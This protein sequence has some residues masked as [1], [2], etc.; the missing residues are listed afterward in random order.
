MDRRHLNLVRTLK[1][2]AFHWILISFILLLLHN[3]TVYGLQKSQYSSNRNELLE[4]CH[5]PTYDDTF[6]IKE[7]E[8]FTTE[9][10]D[11]SIHINIIDNNLLSTLQIFLKSEKLYDVNPKISAHELFKILPQLKNHVKQYPYQLHS[12]L[13]K[14]V[15]WLEKGFDST[16]IQM[17]K[18]IDKHEISFKNL[19][20][21]FPSGS[22]V[23]AK[24]NGKL[25][26]SRVTKWEY[27]SYSGT[28]YFVITGEF[29]NSD[30][31]EFVYIDKTWHIEQFDGVLNITK[32]PVV[33]LQKKCEIR[34]ELV[35]RGKK[36]ELF[37]IGPHYLR[38]SGNF[39][40]KSWFIST[41]SRGDGRIMIDASTF[42]KINPNYDMGL[43][44]HNFENLQYNYNYNTRPKPFLKRKI[45]E[46]EL[47][48]CSPTFFGFSFTAKIWGQ[49]YVDQVDEIKFDDDAFDNLIMDTNKKDIIT[50]LIKSELSGGLD[51]ISGKG[52]GCIFLLHGPPGVGKT[53][54]AE[55]ISEYLHRPLY[56]VSVGELGVTPKE[57]EKKLSEI[58]EVASAW[59]AIILIDEGLCGVTLKNDVNRNALVG[60]FLR[61]L[62]YH[63]GI[64][65][66]TTNRVE[67]FDKAFYSRISLILKYDDLNE[68]ARAQIWRAF[69]D[70][71][72][73][74]DN[75]QVDVDKL[76]QLQLNG[77]EIK[78]AIRL[79]KALATVSDPG[80]IITM[81][82]LEKILNIFA[83]N[84]E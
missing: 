4:H 45:K 75:S 3:F 20:Y 61:L 54:T 18:M 21:L 57:L 50:S 36:F 82:H 41:Y 49:F 51:F 80:A 65:F 31:H 16:L 2:I 9:V 43:A 52:G 29:I 7:K 44:K 6:L 66:L 64:L 55:A 67:S 33:P 56:A 14:L 30:G 84:L 28:Q 38:Y 74:K 10:V 23:Y 42:N 73:G 78:S 77:R 15:D 35:K 83:E 58:L 68:S 5:I 62:E 72:D 70:R 12:P 34:D 37:A 79:A 71:A 24:L 32:L 19:W 81:Q 46:E 11:Y 47:Y 69:L 27:K 22:Q 25:F 1:T 40:Y 76:K 63:K 8:P 59:N 13:K 39:F 26:G 60:I 53:L 17:N 48:M